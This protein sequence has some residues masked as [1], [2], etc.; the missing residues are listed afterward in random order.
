LKR[1]PGNLRRRVTVTI[2]ELEKNPRPANSKR[3]VA[4]DAKREAR[5]VRLGDWRIVY[6]VSEEQ[7]IILAIRRRP[8]YEYAYLESLIKQEASD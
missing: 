2:D 6:L 1:L 8:P 5:R 4:L 7:P 3:L